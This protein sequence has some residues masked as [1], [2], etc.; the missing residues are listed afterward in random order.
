MFYKT[1]YKLLIKAYMEK[2][3]IS[4]ADA[5]KELSWMH[6][7]H[8]ETEDDILENYNISML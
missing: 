1:Q 4:Y 6:K 8:A 5:T 3:N 2:Y 7:I